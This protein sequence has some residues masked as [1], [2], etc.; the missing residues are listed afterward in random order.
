MILATALFSPFDLHCT[1][2]SASVPYIGM[3]GVRNVFRQK[4]GEQENNKSND[5]R[6]PRRVVRLCIWSVGKGGLPVAAAIAKRAVSQ[7]GL[8]KNSERLVR[9]GETR[10]SSC[11]NRPPP[12]SFSRVC[13]NPSAGRRATCHL[14]VCTLRRTDAACR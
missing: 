11:S 2:L 12:A 10:I 1:G 7:K 6:I 4:Q 13:C 14:I 5:K 3:R 8:V 9:K